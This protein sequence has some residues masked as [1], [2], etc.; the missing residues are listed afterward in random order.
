MSIEQ[1]DQYSEDAIA[2][3]AIIIQDQNGNHLLTKIED[4]EESDALEPQ[5]NKNL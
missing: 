5:F 4:L 2:F 3:T 1:M